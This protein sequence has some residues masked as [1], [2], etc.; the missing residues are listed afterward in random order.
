MP[1]GVATVSEAPPLKATSLLLQVC[2]DYITTTAAAKKWTPK[3]L[4]SNQKAADS[5]I[6]LNGDRR[7]GAITQEDMCKAY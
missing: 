1:Q 7:L 6:A 5:L 3:T 4:F 2:S